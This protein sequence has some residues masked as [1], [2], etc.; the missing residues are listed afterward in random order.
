MPASIGMRQRHIDLIKGIIDRSLN[1]LNAMVNEIYSDSNTESP[2][3]NRYLG[4]YSF[5][6][7]IS[8]SLEATISTQSSYD[9]IR[10]TGR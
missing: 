1:R 6:Y 3:R 4:I 5:S 8:T 10:R 2:S 7:D 9:Y